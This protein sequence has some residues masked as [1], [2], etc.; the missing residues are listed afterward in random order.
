MTKKY[1]IKLPPPS[2]I[3]GSSI[4]MCAAQILKARELLFPNVLISQ[5]RLWDDTYQGEDGKVYRTLVPEVNGKLGRYVYDKDHRNW[6]PLEQLPIS[7]ERDTET[8]MGSKEGLISFLQA[9]QEIERR[10]Y[11]DGNVRRILIMKDH[12]GGIAGVCVDQYTGNI[13]GLKEMQEAFE[14]VKDG[15]TN[16]DEK[17]FEFV[18]F[19]ACIMSVYETAVAVEDV[20]NYMV[21]SQESTLGKGNMH[22]TGLLN[23]LSKNPA[24]SGKEL[25]KVICDTGWEESKIVDKNFGL[26]TNTVFT[27]SVIDLSEPKMT[28]LKTAY[29]NFSAEALNVAEK[30]PDDIISTFAKFKSAANVAERFSIFSGNPDMVDLKNFAQNVGD[31]FAELKDSGNTLIKAIDNSVVYNKRGEAFKRGGG[32]SVYYPL[33]LLN[34]GNAIANYQQFVKDEN[35][36]P[37]APSNLYGFLYNNMQGQSVDLSELVD[38]VVYVDDTTKTVSVDLSE[39][40][41]KNVADVHCHLVYC[42]T[43]QDAFGTEKLAALYLGSSGDVKENRQ[44]GTFESNFSGKWIML[45]GQPL[46]VQVVSDSTRKNKYGKKISGTE[47][48]V[49]GILLNEQPYKL[50][51]SRNYPNNKL[52]II[53][54]VPNKDNKATLPS[55]LLESLKKGDVVIPMYVY[56]NRSRD[57]LENANQAE[58]TTPEMARGNPITIGDK[59]KL[60]MGTFREG[61]FA[62][63]FQ[64]GNPIDDKV[65]LANEVVFFKVK[66][67]KVVNVKHAD[68]IEDFRELKEFDAQ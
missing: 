60:E 48:C 19:D 40:D 7:G 35:L 64:F 4:G 59:P 68:Y 27:L 3:I 24:M 57:E 66:D 14:E 5:W 37:E 25:G 30:N 43:Y 10:L 62:Y 8:D 12:G 18:A 63:A 58:K 44:T 2:L 1:I 41:M 55:G 32:I 22:Y 51:F 46:M 17:P 13:I 61:L 47:I 11:P 45:N 54:V 34:N 42:R 16:P 39:E 50:F 15:W 23:S 21:A 67:G 26:S 52:T 65:V 36:S 49:S 56:M 6:H 31:N 20:A 28:A 38:E 9:G 53:G 33:D 29:E